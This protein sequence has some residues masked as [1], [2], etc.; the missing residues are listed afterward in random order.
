MDLAKLGLAAVAG[1]TLL[2]VGCGGSSGGSGAKVAQVGSTQATTTSAAPSGSSKREAMVAFS[3]CMRSH[4]VPKFPDPT[5]SGSGMSLSMGGSGIDRNSPVFEAAD[6]ACRKL[7]PN[8]GEPTPQEQAKHLREALAYAVCMRGHGAPRFP[9][10]KTGPDGGPDFGEIGPSTGVNLNSPQV[11]AAQRAC[12]K[13]LPG[14]PTGTGE[15][16]P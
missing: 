3:A 2:A 10:P 7:L 15:G 11:K 1:L 12:H 13:L 16:T 9:D 5:V 14:S 6:R 8:G 4:G